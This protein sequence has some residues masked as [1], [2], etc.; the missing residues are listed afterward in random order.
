M[1]S[2]QT[3]LKTV[4]FTLDSTET[5]NFLD[6]LRLQ[7]RMDKSAIPSKKQ[8]EHALIDFARNHIKDNPS[9]NWELTLEST[10]KTISFLLTISDTSEVDEA[11]RQFHTDIL[12]LT[13]KQYR[14]P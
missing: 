1:A 10:G 6:Y 4:R 9:V 14:V 13:W 7:L 3:L 12:L 2:N 11:I 8:I 5:K